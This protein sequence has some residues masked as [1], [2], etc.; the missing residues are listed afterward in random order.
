MRTIFLSFFLTF[1]HSSFAT[2]LPSPTLGVYSLATE[3][4]WGLSFELR[5]AGEAEIIPEHETEGDEETGAT[6][7]IPKAIKGTWKSTASGIEISYGKSKGE[8]KDAFKFEKNCKEWN[9]KSC[10][11]FEK[12][13]KNPLNK[14]PLHYGQAYLHS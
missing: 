13:L 4:G 11:R 12:S 7:E 10:F 6:A 3:A 9:Q 5:A 1:M 8:F 2:P 14:S